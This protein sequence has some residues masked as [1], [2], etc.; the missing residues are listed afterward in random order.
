[1]NKNFIF[2]GFFILFQLFFGN[3]HG[4]PLN[5]MGDSKKCTVASYYSKRFHGKKTASGEKFN[6][7]D[8]TAAHKTIK[9]GTKIHVTNQLTGKSVTVK[10]NDRGPYV[11]GRGLD[12]SLAAAKQL[13]MINQ[14]HGKVCYTIIQ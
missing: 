14:G 12:L 13:E 5:G 8:Y 1:M 11:K 2:L 10:I 7:H 4:K 3:A 9:F 6:I